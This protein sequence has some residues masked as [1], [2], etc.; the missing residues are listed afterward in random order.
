MY[1]MFIGSIYAPLVSHI[2]WFFS[3]SDL[4]FPKSALIYYRVLFVVPLSLII[5]FIS[6]VVKTDIVNYM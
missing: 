5:R 3:E 4:D 1:F 6:G 2:G